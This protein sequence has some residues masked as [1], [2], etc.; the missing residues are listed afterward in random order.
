MKPRGTRHHI[1]FEAAL[2][3]A[4]DE[5]TKL[6]RN[7]SCIVRLAQ[8]PH[9]ELHKAVTCVPVPNIYM[10]RHMLA[11]FEPGDD[12]FGTIDNLCFA[13]ESARKHPKANL[14][15]RELGSLI[16]ASFRAQIPYIRD[17]IMQ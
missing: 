4:R 10:A 2:W 9:T 11:R 3:E 17:G 12:I 16:I 1:A 14:L 7:G 13:T 6:R 8:E 15:D 5:T